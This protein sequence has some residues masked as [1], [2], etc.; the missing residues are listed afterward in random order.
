MLGRAVRASS[1]LGVRPGL[2][3]PETVTTLTW[4]AGGLSLI[5]AIVVVAAPA[6]GTNRLLGVAVPLAVAAIALMATTVPLRPAFMA[7][8]LYAAGLLALI[9]AI[10]LALSVPVRLSVEGI[11][12]RTSASCPLGFDYPVTAGENFAVYAA[13]VV[14]FGAIVFAFAAIEA[15]YIRKPRRDRTDDRL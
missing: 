10:I 1:F 8:V 12:P 4:V 13:T 9:Y 6:G 2:P 3:R 15:R 5:G 14:A 11:C 7:V